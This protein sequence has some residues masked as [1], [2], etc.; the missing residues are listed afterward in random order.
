MMQFKYWVNIIYIYIFFFHINC[1]Y[2]I[3]NTYLN[4]EHQLLFE[5][6]VIF[7]LRQEEKVGWSRRA[8]FP[9]SIALLSCVC[10]CK[11]ML[12]VKSKLLFLVFFSCLPYIKLFVYIIGIMLKGFYWCFLWRTFCIRP[13]RIILQCFPVVALNINKLMIRQCTQLLSLYY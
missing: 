11:A 13:K 12:T 9:I 6:A 7:S 8:V 5:H 1:H 4:Y 2:P 10:I 3:N